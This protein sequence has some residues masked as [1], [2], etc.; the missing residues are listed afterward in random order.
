MKQEQ[1]AEEEWLTSTEKTIGSA[2]LRLALVL[3]EG[4]HYVSSLRKTVRCLLE[5]VNVRREDIEDIELAIGELAAN[6]M[7]HGDAPFTLGINYH[8][9]H[10]VLLMADHGT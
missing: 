4:R 8:T 5:S 2:V 1:Y 3:P 6:A 10:I 9:D 7:M